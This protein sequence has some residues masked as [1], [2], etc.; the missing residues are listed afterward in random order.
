MDPLTQ[1]SLGAAVAV[2]V[3]PRR[4]ARSALLLGALAGAAPDLDVLIR[5][6]A[7]PLLGVQ[8]HRHFSHGMLTAPVIGLCVAAL[9]KWLFARS[10]PPLAACAR[11]AVL[12]ALTHGLLDACT[13]YGTLLYWPFSMHRE[14]WDLISVIDPLFTLPLVG[15]TVCALIWRQPRC[16]QVALL[17]CALYLGFCGVQHARASQA[18]EQLAAA[19]GHHPERYSIRPSFGNSLLWRMIYRAE[20][21]YYVDAVWILPGAEPR[22]YPGCSVAPFEPSDAAALVAADSVLGRDIERFRFFSQGYVSVH[23]SDPQVLGD[24]R[25]ALWPDSVRPLWGIRINPAHPD[26]HVEWVTYRDT[27]QAA[28]ER[29]WSMIQGRP[30]APLGD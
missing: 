22:L 16:A 9:F 2:A 5:S 12:G 1:A 10:A 29:L 4:H 23:S 18:A 20:G 19:R 14:S 6:S 15:L 25:Y 27:S 17:F 7:D 13:S 21:R 8:Y 24:V 26:A 28:R 11:Y 3:S 30:V